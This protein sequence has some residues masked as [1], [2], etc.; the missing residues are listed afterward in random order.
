MIKHISSLVV[1]GVAGCGKSSVAQALAA[2]IGGVLIEGDAFHPQAN[3]DKMARG[4]PL[5]DEDRAGWLDRLS[6]EIERVANGGQRAVLAC[7]ALKQRYRNRLRTA[8]ASLGF[9]FLDLPP[10]EALRRVAQ[11]ESHFMPA[12]LVESQFATLERPVAEPLTLTVDGTLSLASIVREA[13]AW[14]GTTQAHLNYL[15]P[16]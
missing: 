14:C 15:Q 7:S 2:R 3:V 10:A 4:I 16:V 8:T 6:D 13:A 1:M 9:I 12:S 11:R 5:T